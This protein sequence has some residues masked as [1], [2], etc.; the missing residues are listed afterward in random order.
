MDDVKEKRCPFRVFREKTSFKYSGAEAT[1]EKFEPCIGEECA[2]YYL[3]GCI[4]LP[5]PYL[6]ANGEISE[7]DLEKLLEEM[8]NTPIMVLSSEEAKK[9]E[10]PW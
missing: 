7:A 9:E 5:P 8:R 2:A 6:L 1:T 4:R 10:I 3:G